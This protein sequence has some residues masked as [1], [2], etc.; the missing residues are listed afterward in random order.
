MTIKNVNY[1]KKK[2]K[3]TFCVTHISNTKQYSTKVSGY[4]YGCYGIYKA[5]HDTKHPWNVILLD[6]GSLVVRL[7]T[8]NKA[9]KLVSI[10]IS[11]GYNGRNWWD[12]PE[13]YEVKQIVNDF[14]QNKFG[15]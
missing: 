11:K 10:L 12:S 5:D 2:K 4:V 15:R 9:R 6:T 1:G 13:K 7:S 8:F 3:E 14:L